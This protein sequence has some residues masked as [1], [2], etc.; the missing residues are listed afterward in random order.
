MQ[1]EVPDYLRLLE[2]SGTLLFFDIETNNLNADY[3]EAVVFSGKW[4]G[5]KRPFTISQRDMSERRMLT[6]VKSILEDQADCI[7]SYNGK[8]FDVPFLNTRC[9]E[10]RK[11]PLPKLHHIDL[12]FTLKPKLRTG[13]KALGTIG[14]WLQL[15]ED[16]MS[17]PPKAWREKN[18]KKL[19][20]RCESD[21]LLLEQLYDRTKHLI[22]DI[23][24]G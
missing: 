23:K 17:V 7:V 12:Y 14:N 21:V 9:L 5:A 2:N 18:Y 24:K 11:D 8:R 13:R 22:Y 10:F 20:A 3:G 4:F 19:I 16:K 1:I 15:Q 6:E